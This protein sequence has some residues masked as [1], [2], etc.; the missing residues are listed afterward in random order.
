MPDERWPGIVQHPL[1][2]ASRNIFIAAVAFKHRAFAVVCNRLRFA[3]VIFQRS[4]RSIA[5]IQPVGKNVHGSEPLATRVVIPDII[6]RPQMLFRNKS[7]HALQSRN[8]RARAGFGVVAVSAARSRIG[9]P[10]HRRNIFV[11]A[12][13]FHAGV[14]GNRCRRCAGRRNRR[15]RPLR[16]MQNGQIHFLHVGGRRVVAAIQPHENAGMIAQTPRL[17][18]HRSSRNFARV[19]RP[20]VPQFPGVAAGPSGHHQNSQFIGFVEQFVTIDAPLQANRVQTHVLHVAQIRIQ[21]FRHRSQKHIWRPRCAANQNPPAIYFEKPM[22]FFGKFAG[23]LSNS[24][25]NGSR[26]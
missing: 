25:R 23:D 5:L 10:V 3:L 11:R 15:I 13:H 2:Y 6:H 24:K 7:F 8:C 12:G 19:R 17:I 20:F 1:N 21:L 14:S 16:V 4:R 22:A 26:I 9:Q 18:G